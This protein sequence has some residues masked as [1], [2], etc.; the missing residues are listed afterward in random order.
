[1]NLKQTGE[2]VEEKQYKLGRGPAYTILVVLSLL[3]LVDWADRSILA[4]GLQSIKQ[5][6]NLTDA[7]AGMLPSLLQFGV[8]IM[9]VPVAIFADRWARRKVIAVM[10]IIWSTFTLLTGLGTQL[11][12]LLVARFMVGAGEA[13]Y[14]PAGLSWL[15]VIF[16]KS[17][18]SRIFGIF[19]SFNPIG[20]ALGLM[21]GGVLISATH[22]WRVPFYVFAVPG[23]LLAIWVFFLPD[24]KVEK[25][26]GERMLSRSFFQDWG[27]IFRSR[28]F[29]MITASQVFIYFTFFAFISWAPTLVQRAF[30]LDAGTAGMTLGLLSFI[31][32]VGPFGGYLADKWQQR[33]KNGRPLF[34]AIVT[35][36]TLIV[37]IIAWQLISLPFAWWLPI[38]A[39]MSALVAFTQ[40]VNQTLIHD[41]VPV[42]VRATAFGTM[43]LIAQLFG[44]MTGPFV[45]GLLSDRLGGGAQGM[46][47]GLTAVTFVGLIGIILI[48]VAMKFYPSDSAKV[49]DVV[50][51]EK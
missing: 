25:Q 4:I 11:W 37:G 32:I 13:G 46:Q 47:G 21:L 35:T 6:F 31:Y 43:N 40:P 33:N 9:T 26:P 23:F 48:F 12:H 2:K 28:A 36:V 45:V 42:G 24:Y 34:S 20:T 14:V 3:Q 27:E 5:S 7:Q 19:T 44:G 1:M 10:D 16:P 29:C 50:M 22:D 38:Y 18:R 39:V 8:V 41:V 15:G 30:N 17:I 49:S 51:A